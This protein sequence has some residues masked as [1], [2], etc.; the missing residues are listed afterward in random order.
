MATRFLKPESTFAQ[1]DLYARAMTDNQS[2]DQLNHE[3]EK[4]FQRIKSKKAA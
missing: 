4:L 2:A 3:R 1:L